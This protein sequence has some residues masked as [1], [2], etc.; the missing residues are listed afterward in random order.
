MGKYFGRICFALMLAISLVLVSA[1]TDEGV[2]SGG[3]APTAT[4][5]S[6]STVTFSDEYNKND[7][8]LIYWYLCGTD[9]E[10]NYGAASS[11]FGELV[12]NKLPP[13]VKVLVQTGGTVEWQNEVVPDG[14]VARFLY[15][16]EDLKLLETLPD[17]DM[18]SERT[19]ED[20]L[21][22]GKENFQADHRVFVFWD[23]GGGSVVGICYDERT[24]HFL[25]LNDLNQAFGAVFE[26]SAEN[27]PFEIIGF[28][29]CLMAT[30]D[31]AKSLQGFAKFM[32]GSEEVEPGNGWKYDGWVGALAN[33]PAM[34]GA[35]LG[36]AIC[37]SYMQGCQEYDTDD[38]AT[39]SLIDMSKIPELTV[40][41]EY[42]GLEAIKN[43]R[44]DPRGFFST[45][46]R[47]A[48]RAENYGG[49]TRSS[50]FTNMVDL[51]D[52]AR[53][54]KSILP[55]TSNDLIN[56]IDTAVVYKVQGDYRQK[57]SGLS[58]FYSYDGTEEN[59]VGYLNVDS[60][61]I[62]QKILYYYLIYGEIPDEALQII[63]DGSFEKALS[64]A[65]SQIAASK[66]APVL[67]EPAEISATPPAQR[68]NLFNV[69]SLEDLPV[70][71]DENGN[72]FVKLTQE[73]MDILSSVHC[74]LI[75]ISVEDDIMLFLGSDANIDAD[76][77]KGIFKDNFQGLWPCLDGH[78]VYM[79]IVAEDD[80]Y[81]LY[82]VPIKLN[83]VE[84][85][86]QVVYNYKDEK[87]HI[88]GAR[89]GI[90]DNGMS[91]RE[92]IKLKAGDQ[93]TTIHYGTLIS[94]ESDDLTPVDVDT[95]T[96]N[97]ANPKFEDEDMGD[98]LFGYCFEFVSPT[99]DSSLSKLVQFEVK[100]GE[101]TTSVE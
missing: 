55:T 5:S 59:L 88:L 35:S 83:G 70:D 62:S 25:S 39:L 45:F 31:T 37:D 26:S 7:T 99:D 42:F 21:R 63:N 82:N 81:N 57:G 93:I 54:S 92:L 80:D 58:G 87:Y 69:A 12:Q 41:Y 8:W 29:A 13:N 95:F 90:E 91:D 43:A 71:I 68:Q 2:S 19:L 44:Q 79:E 34:G 4:R 61:P 40:A 60:A 94:S 52:L 56:A 17:A 3:A 65:K 10:S 48:K 86:L 46:G 20:F 9:L 53:Q 72:A 30:Y 28:D 38:S 97:S 100:N 11:D 66:P 36:K 98:G 33:N 67:E 14:Q 51:G 78:L 23:H 47:G 76:W 1:C 22:Y 16:S 50:G 49:N 64:E 89:K 27:P 73:Q 74:Q 24:G 15:D 75:Y 101:I 77:D 6:K 32:V 84:C 96:I 18:G 85:N